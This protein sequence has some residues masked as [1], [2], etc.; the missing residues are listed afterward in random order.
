MKKMLLMSLLMI[1]CNN[2]TEVEEKHVMCS[3]EYNDGQSGCLLP[4]YSSISICEEKCLELSEEISEIQL[5]EGME[6]TCREYSDTTAC[7][8]GLP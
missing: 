4:T 8:L 3:W 1:G 5:L 7:L 2:S 6:L